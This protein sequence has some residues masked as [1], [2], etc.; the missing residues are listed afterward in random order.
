MEHQIRKHPRRVQGMIDDLNHPE[1]CL[2]CFSRENLTFDH[3]HPT[4]K[5]GKDCTYT[6]GQIL[7]DEC[8]INKSND[9][10]SIK[11]LRKRLVEKYREIRNKKNEERKFYHSN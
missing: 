7:C 9:I 8:N 1:Y 4:S 11:D 2:C 3:I 10:I 5:G 6:N